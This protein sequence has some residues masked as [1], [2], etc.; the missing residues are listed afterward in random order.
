MMKNNNGLLRIVMDWKPQ[1][2]KPHGRPR[3]KMIDG[4]ENDL[5]TLE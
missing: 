5:K 3:K 1:E 4:V 2:E